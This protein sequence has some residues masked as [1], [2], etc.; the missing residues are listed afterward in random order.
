LQL[1]HATR[2]ARFLDL[3]KLPTTE[4]EADLCIVGA[5][6]TGLALAHE[7]ASS[8]RR[9]VVVESGGRAAGE[10]AE[11]L[12]MGENVGDLAL[13]LQHS[14]ARGV[15]GTTQL[16]AG[17][18]VPFEIDDFSEREWVPAAKWPFQRS[19][20]EPYYRGAERLLG[21]PPTRYDES[22]WRN[23]RVPLPPLDPAVLRHRCTVMPREVN[24]SALTAPRLRDAV[25]VSVLLHATVA[26]VLV[27]EAGDQ[28]DGIELRSLGG[29]SGRVRAS[30]VVL[31]A[32]AIENA[33]ILLLSRSRHPPGGAL[34]PGPSQCVFSR[35]PDRQS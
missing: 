26:Q 28:V 1:L 5:G 33:R 13:E 19:E 20:L 7:L 11:A 4:L 18:C 3:D 25:N 32:G 15:G 24:M 12:N 31:C 35:G 23:F 21:V 29:R 6:A 2:A 30:L 34:P 16:W 22:V 14:R 9:I 27:T 17:Q 8:G 10:P